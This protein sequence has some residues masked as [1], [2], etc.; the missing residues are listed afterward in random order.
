MSINSCMLGE[1][2]LT[3]P[4]FY[5]ILEYSEFYKLLSDTTMHRMTR[6]IQAFINIDTYVFTSMSG[7]LESIHD[8]LLKGRINDSYSLLRKL[9]D[10]AI[11][12]IYTNLYIEENQDFDNY[13]IEKINDWING[14]YSI[15]SFQKMSDYI[16][17]SER[18]KEITRIL[19]PNFNFKESIFDRIRKRCNS[20]S[21]YLSYFTMLSNDN[22]V[23]LENRLKMLNQFS[24]DVEEISVLHLSYL[25]Y[26]KDYYMM[27]SDHLD[28]LECG[29]PPVEGSEYWVAPFIKEQFHKIFEVKRPVI[30]KIIR[31]HTMMEI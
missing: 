21:H 7:T 13:F 25:F 19:Y 11:I 2:Y 27:S 26:L 29:I 5:K 30:A 20:H 6:G 16:I 17:K 4:V 14:D 18:L 1:N 10:S 28:S 9:Y 24:E 15:P 8:I 3:N 23:Y 12:N 31:E 22:S